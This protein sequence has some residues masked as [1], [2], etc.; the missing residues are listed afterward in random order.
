MTNNE[1][2]E[3]AYATALPTTK[4][5]TYMLIGLTNEAGEAAGKYKKVLRGDTTLVDSKAAIAD[6]LA[7]CLWYI[8][9]AATVMGYTMDELMEMNINKLASRKERG[10]IQGNGDNR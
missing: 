3:K 10:V 2:Q 5:V 6:E 7:D 1:Y 8:A 4:N 9:G